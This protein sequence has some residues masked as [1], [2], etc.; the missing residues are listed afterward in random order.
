MRV[1]RLYHAGP[2]T[3]PQVL[4][5]NADTSHHLATVLR[6][7]V[8]DAVVIF[9]G[10]GAEY[11]GTIEQTHKKQVM[12]A[13]THQVLVQRE[14]SIQIHLGQGLCRGEKM[15]WVIQK[16]V[17]LG[18]TEIT[19]LITDHSNVKLD[20]ERSD[21]KHQHWQQVMISACEQ[22][23]RTVVPKLH[24]VKPLAQWILETNAELKW[25]L[26]PN[27]NQSLKNQTKPN[28]IALLIG[29]E[30]GLSNVEIAAA[31][32][33][34]FN[35]IQLGPRVLR[36]ETAPIVALSVVQTLWGDF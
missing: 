25:L 20:A 24:P 13:I 6:A 3:C 23:G 31:Q 33:A 5:L 18:V 1:T 7:N 35:S 9:N 11:S 21:K 30:G 29:P 27:D 22:S 14:S 34:G 16:S 32:N 19:P 26:N 36:T 12:V 4:A 28:S 10:D 8:G 2:I 17:E 15:D